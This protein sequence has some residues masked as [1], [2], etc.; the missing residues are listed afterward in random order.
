MYLPLFIW[1]LC[2]SLLWFA[3][4]YYL[5]S[6]AIIMTRKRLLVTLPLL[7]F[8]RQATVNVL[9][10]FSM[11]LWVGLQFVILVF[12][13]LTFIALFDHWGKVG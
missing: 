5:S 8:G 11:M 12:P 1:V 9:W 4:L 2:W 3:L 7:S 13:C 10:L 6:S